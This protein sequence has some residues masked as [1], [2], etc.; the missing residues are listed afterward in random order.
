[1]LVSRLRMLALSVLA[2]AAVAA[3]P[4]DAQTFTNPTPFTIPDFGA[5]SLYPSTILVSGIAGTVERVT[6]TLSG[7]EH[8]YPRDVDVMVVGPAGQNLVVMSDTP[9]ALI[10]PPVTFNFDDFALS[11]LPAG[12]EAAGSGTWRPTNLGTLDA[13][14]APAPEPSAAT[15]LATFN[16]T[17]PNGL[18]SL[19]VTDD[20][21]GDSGALGG[22]SITF[23]PE[24]GP[25]AQWVALLALLGLARSMRGR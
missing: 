22:W 18:W 11:E 10:A 8:G 3:A 25:A 24:P 4:A 21:P 20:A 1:M 16:G 7:Y 23:A 9:F 15:Q 12:I 19:Y 2:A 6:V 17:N 13:F 14:P 5:A